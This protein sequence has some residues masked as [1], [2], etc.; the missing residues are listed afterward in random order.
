MDFILVLTDEQ[1]WHTT[2][3][4]CLIT[5]L[6]CCK[7]I[8]TNWFPQLHYTI[9]YCC[10]Q[11][12]LSSDWDLLQAGPSMLHSVLQRYSRIDKNLPNFIHCDRRQIVPV[13]TQ[14]GN[15]QVRFNTAESNITYP[16]TA[17]KL[18]NLISDMKWRSFFVWYYLGH[19]AGFSCPV[20]FSV[21]VSCKEL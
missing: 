18:F 2:T 13:A 14:Q 9:E 15:F 7:T 8:N 16:D 1:S 20:A 17:Q 11:C 10:C 12:G 5:H 3:H 21:S 19:L 4:G 6:A